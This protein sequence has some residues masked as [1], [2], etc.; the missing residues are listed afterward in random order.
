MTLLQSD[1]AIL[2]LALFTRR[3]RGMP[4]GDVTKF[5]AKSCEREENAWVLGWYIKFPT[6]RN[7]DNRRITWNIIK[8]FTGSRGVKF[9][10]KNY[11][12]NILPYKI[13]N[14]VIWSINMPNG[15][16]VNPIWTA[17]FSFRTL[18]FSIS[19]SISLSIVRHIEKLLLTADH[20]SAVA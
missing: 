14:Q 1:G 13:H 4:L 12:S 8:K 20:S 16:F 7:W 5:R 10:R 2:D 15:T 9:V 18:Y 17:F 19:I 3:S 6:R 11:P